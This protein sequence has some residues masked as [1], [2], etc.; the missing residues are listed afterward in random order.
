VLLMVAGL[1]IRSFQRLHGVN[2]GFDPHGVLTVNVAVAQ[3]E[4]S[5]PDQQVR[6]FEQVLQ[7]VR[8]LPAVDAA[9][10]ADDIPLN[11]N[12]SN[13]PI[14]IEG[15]P[16][17]AMADQPEVDVRLVSTGYMRALRIPVLRGRDFSD[18]DI[19]GRPGAVLISES[20]A[21]RFWP[22]EDAI[23]KRLKLTFFPDF[24][25]EIVG[26][27]GDVKLDGLD[28]TRPAVALYVPLGQLSVP[29]LGGWSSFPMT[30]VVRTTT[31]P[32]ALVSAVSNAIHQINPDVPLQDIFPM[33][34]VVTN[35]LSQQR[36]NMLLLGTFAGLALTLAAVGIYSVLS[37]SVKRRVN[38]IGIRLA[39]GARL[40]DVL[41]MVVYEGM[42]PTVLGIAIGVIVALGL[43]RFISRLIYQ[44]TPGD[45]LTFLA[46][47]TLLTT[48]ALLACVIPAYRASK[49]DPMVAL[50]YE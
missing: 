18:T 38:E 20:M 5:S 7:Q 47:A 41:R 24:S 43:G 28:Q 46:V 3:K 39:L 35:S 10:V 23:G 42:K 26:V 12:G 32:S 8:A 13:Q 45:P 33:D 19:A 40:G 2:P 49:V 37:Y 25:R 1:L 15:R 30:L 29:A 16:E 27:V 11:T 31:T 48:V 21:Q 14:A 6:F 4:F 50:R 22:G 36:F 9:G 44:V 17:V 34:D